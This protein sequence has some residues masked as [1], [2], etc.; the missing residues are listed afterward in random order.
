MKATTKKPQGKSNEW[1]TPARYVEAA[2]RVMGGIDLDPASC[3]LA[4]ETVKAAQYFSE[5]D[6]GLTQEWHGRVWLNPPYGRIDPEKRGST[7][8]HQ[9][10]FIQ[11]LL[12]AYQQGVVDQAICLVIGTSCFMRWFQPLWEYPLC[13]H[14]GRIL[15]DQPDGTQSDFGFGN[16]IAYLGPNEQAFINEF[17]AFGTITKR[18]D[19]PRQQGSQS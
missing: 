2:R 5:E 11:K 18:V 3:A 12:Q 17:S 8:S 4:N 16:I 9:L 1:Y 10:L 15:F 19:T 13:F 6:D 7:K 14:D